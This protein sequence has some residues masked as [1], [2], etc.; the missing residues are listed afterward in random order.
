MFQSKGIQLGENEKKFLNLLENP[1]NPIDKNVRLSENG[2]EL[3]WP[4]VF[5]YPEYGQTDFIESF[6][7]NTK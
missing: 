7:E 5:L 3:I 6:H 4:V 1:S 2:T